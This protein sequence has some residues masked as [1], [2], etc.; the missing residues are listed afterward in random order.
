M[1]GSLKRDKCLDNYS[2]VIEWRIWTSERL[3]WRIWTLERLNSTRSMASYLFESQ[4]KPSLSSWIH[5]QRRPF[6]KAYSSRTDKK[7]PY[8]LRH[9]DVRYS[10]YSSPPIGSFPKSFKKPT[11]HFPHSLTFISIL[12]SSHTKFSK[13]LFLS[14]LPSTSHFS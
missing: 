8:H 9:S 13:R 4:K 5:P 6:L 11:F 12:I 2:S 14:S 10:I 7:I 1:V 3:K